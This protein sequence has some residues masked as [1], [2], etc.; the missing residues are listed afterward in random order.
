MTHEP[1][2]GDAECQSHDHAKKR[3]KRSSVSRN[4]RPKRKEMRRRRKGVINTGVAVSEPTIEKQLDGNGRVK[5]PKTSSS[6]L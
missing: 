1:G 4:R 6:N 2:V 5:D 3:R